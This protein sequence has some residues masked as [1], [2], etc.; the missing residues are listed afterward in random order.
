MQVVAE[1]ACESL[2]NEELEELIFVLTGAATWASFDKLGR[3]MLSSV[4]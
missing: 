1:L 3:T 4:G 2:A